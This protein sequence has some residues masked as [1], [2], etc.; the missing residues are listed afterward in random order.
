MIFKPYLI[1]LNKFGTKDDEPLY[2]NN[3]LGWGDKKG[4]T[5]FSL[6]ERINLDL[7]AEGRWRY[8][9]DVLKEEE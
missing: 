9:N 6:K 3:D 7:P 1:E 5:C 4:A 8:D 2:W